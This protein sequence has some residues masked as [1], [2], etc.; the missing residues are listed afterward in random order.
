VATT[1]R[2]L[3]NRLLACSGIYGAVAVPY[4]LGFEKLAIIG[5]VARARRLVSAIQHSLDCGDALEAQIFNRAL[6]EYALTI[7]WMALGPD[8]HTKQWLIED[9]RQTLVM[10][11]EVGQELGE[12]LLTDD[13]RARLEQVSEELRAACG[14]RPTGVPNLQARAQAIGLPVLYT[15]GYRYESKSGIHPTTLA[16]E[17]LITDHKQ[18]KM[19]EIREEPA[20]DLALPDTEGVSLALLLAILEAAEQLVPELKLDPEFDEVRREILA[21]APLRESETV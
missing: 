18:A 6:V 5:L 1:K 12:P 16:G 19:H 4:G 3:G 7:P 9:I 15:L 14:E 10:D 21:L 8:L 20:A 11:A 17:Q 13:H 2:D